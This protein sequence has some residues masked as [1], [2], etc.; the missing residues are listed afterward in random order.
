MTTL[1]ILCFLAGMTFFVLGWMILVQKRLWKTAAVLLFSLAFILIF[2]G[3]YSFWYYH[4]PLPE[5]VQNIPLFQG[6]TYTREVHTSPRPMIIHIVTVNL[7]APGIHFFVT[8]GELREDDM[9][10][11][12]RT[13]SQFVEEFGVQFGKNRQCKQ[14]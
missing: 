6:I 2:C 13:T 9:E 3:G 4:R 10:F 12:A 5:A 7:D 1:T 11:P 14:S 8:P